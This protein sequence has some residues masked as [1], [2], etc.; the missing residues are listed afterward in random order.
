MD[1]AAPGQL[2][3]SNSGVSTGGRWKSAISMLHSPKE[4]SKTPCIVFCQ[5]AGRWGVVG[6]KE[7]L[8]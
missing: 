3:G 7:V 4:Q 1:K 8:L 2:G 6:G 5:E